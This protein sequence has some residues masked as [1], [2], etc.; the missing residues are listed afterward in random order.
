MEVYIQFFA[1]DRVQ[2]QCVPRAKLARHV[3]CAALPQS[4]DV[5]DALHVFPDSPFILRIAQQECWMI[6]R[7]DLDGAESVETPAQAGDFFLAV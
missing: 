1:P 4:Q 3:R 2:K 5:L 7:H 6:G